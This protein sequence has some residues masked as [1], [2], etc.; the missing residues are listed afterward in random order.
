MPSPG[1][2]AIVWTRGAFGALA[3]GAAA[4][5]GTAFGGAATGV[6]GGPPVGATGRA[7]RP[8]RLGSLVALPFD[9]FAMR[10]SRARSPRP[11]PRRPDR[12]GEAR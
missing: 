12:A 7:P 8:W 6:F 4:R 3:L 5:A 11:D 9:A 1:S 2:T 10:S